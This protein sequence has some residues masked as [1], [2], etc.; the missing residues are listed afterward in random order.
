[1]K[2]F[3]LGAATG[4]PASSISA[5]A[6]GWFGMRTPTV[7]N[8]AVTLSGT[9]LFLGSTSVNGPGHHWRA[10]SSASGGH[11]ATI[12]RA[13]STDATCTI[14]GLVSGRPFISNIF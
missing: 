11:S 6:I 1:M 9:M 12:S 2:R 4:T 3:A 14:S 7:G 10:S 5:S 13:I 8:P